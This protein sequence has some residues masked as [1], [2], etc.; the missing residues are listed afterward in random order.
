[1]GRTR[2]PVGL[3]VLKGTA[4]LTRAEVSE[5]REHEVAAPECELEPPGWLSGEAAEMFEREAA[6]MLAVN[7]LSG[8]NV[9]GSTDAACLALMCDAYT[10]AA[11]M[12]LEMA[13]A[14]CDEGR[15]RARRAKQ[16]E[17]R[18]YLECRKSL[19]L[20]P[21]DRASICVPGEGNGSAEPEF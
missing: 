16:S 12:S 20:G 5:R 4:H 13:T 2:D 3:A 10:Q 9:Y 17:E 1:M 7:D 21:S 6:Y 15:E 8:A 19:K 14:E 11:R 18:V